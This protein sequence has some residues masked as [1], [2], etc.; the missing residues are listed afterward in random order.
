MSERRI[1]IRL[2]IPDNEAYTAL[3]ALRALDVP[4]E[5][6]ERS[7]IWRVEDGGDPSTLA[8]RIETNEAIFNPNKHR[9]TVLE[10]AR[11]RAGEVWIERL[12]Q[13]PNAT[14]W[15]LLDARG[16][17]LESAELHAAAERLLC[18]P[19]IEKAVY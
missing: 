4:V 6:L 2:K 19:A 12:G 17:P 7:E 14:A 9:V 13:G 5:R 1:A 16:E 15:R 18:N 11:P 8:V 3:T 10:E